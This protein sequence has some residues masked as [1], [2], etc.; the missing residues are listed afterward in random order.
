LPK[1]ENRKIRPLKVTLDEVRTIVAENDKQR[2][3]LIPITEA[4]P[5]SVAP[6]DVPASDAV[7]IEFEP[8][9][10][11]PSNY[12]IRANQ[13]HSIKVPE[14]GLLDPITLESG[15]LPKIVVHGT[16]TRAWPLI[17][18]SGG[19]KTMARTHVHFASGLPEGFKGLEDGTEDNKEK[20]KEPVISG[21]RNTSSV[22]IY[23]DIEKALTAGL[24]FW[25]SQNG[26]ILGN[27]DEAGIIPLEFFERVEDRKIGSIIMRNGK[28]A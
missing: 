19:L 1:L 14:D 8:D 23:L 12:L 27:G 28:N 9:L 6:Q 10:H 24:K 20:R 13:G 5:A 21:M 17:V 26:V 3:S 15:D 4:P 2:F 18:R 25:R 22:L 11:D 7:A 16:T